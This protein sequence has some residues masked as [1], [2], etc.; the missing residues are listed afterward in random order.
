MGLRLGWLRGPLVG[1][2][3]PPPA[4]RRPPPS[5]ALTVSLDALGGLAATTSA[6]VDPLG[7][8]LHRRLA[9]LQLRQH[10]G[11]DEDRRVGA[12]RD[13]HEEGER[14]VLQRA[15]TEHVGTDEEQAATGSSPT[16]EV[17]MDRTSVWLTAR[18]AAS[19]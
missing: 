6:G 16:I 7:Q 3:A 19:L 11:G 15:G 12:D 2:L 9:L 4:T 18:L 10:R 5:V 17:L 14:E 13:A 1:E 8:G